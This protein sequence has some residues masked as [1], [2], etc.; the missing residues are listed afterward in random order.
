MYRSENNSP[1]AIQICQMNKEQRKSAMP[2]SPI[3]VFM[4]ASSSEKSFGST[5]K[6]SIPVQKCVQRRKL[7][8]KMKNIRE[9]GIES[10]VFFSL[11]NENILSGLGRFL[12][13]IFMYK[14]YRTGRNRART[15]GDIIRMLPSSEAVLLERKTIKT[16]SDKRQVLK[17]S[18]ESL[19]RFIKWRIKKK[20][21]QAHIGKKPMYM[22]SPIV[23]R[24]REG[25]KSDKPRLR[26][27]L[28]MFEIMVK[29]MAMAAPMLINTQKPAMK[30]QGIERKSIGRLFLCL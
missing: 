4:A 9:S 10:K 2:R 30:S 7:I 5:E 29:R 3:P 19:N 14:R 12:S 8:P 20:E 16:A 24:I 21:I 28:Q 18:E 11:C 15:A 6:Y 1:S 17:A 26:S 25:T 23:R 22:I 27:E 13:R